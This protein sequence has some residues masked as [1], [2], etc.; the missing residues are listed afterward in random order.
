MAKSELELLVSDIKKSTKQISINKVDEVRVM[1]S[2]LNDRDFSLSI[3]DK[4]LGYIGQKC[5]H[6]E[7]VNFIKNII[8]GA[9]G[10]DR[11]NSLHLAENYVF[12]KSDASYMVDNAK[13]FI[14]VY[15]ETGRKLNVM[16]TAATEACIYTKEVSATNKTIPDKENPGQVKKITTS[17]YIKLVSNTKAPKYQ[18][19]NSSN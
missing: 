12:T 5:P 19:D 7:A 11:K 3:Y 8:S 6:D 1:K 18:N 2:M 4:N 14:Q 16:Q 9:T 13:D 15:M 10:L 17:P